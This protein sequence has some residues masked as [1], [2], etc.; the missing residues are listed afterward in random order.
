[1]VIMLVYAAVGGSWHVPRVLLMATNQ[2]APL[3]S[4]SIAV[5]AL[6]VA[7]A[8]LLGRS[9]ELSGV[10]M[11][12]L[13]SELAIALVCIRLALRLFQTPQLRVAKP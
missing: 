5:G 2:H 11:G 6:T 12:M 9:F 10:A 4:W 8:W 1:M 13:L 7:L 3:A